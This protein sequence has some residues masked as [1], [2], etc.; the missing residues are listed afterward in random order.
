LFGA[1]TGGAA[2][3]AIEAVAGRDV[4]DEVI[5]LVDHSLLRRAGPDRY[6]AL[7]VVRE[8]AARCLDQRPDAEA[9]RDRHAAFFASEVGELAAE[10][11]DPEWDRADVDNLRAAADRSYSRDL[12]T[13]VRVSYRLL[14][15]LVDT[16]QLGEAGQRATALLQAPLTT[17][18]Q[19]RVHLIRQDITFRRGRDAESLAEVRTALE[20]ARASGDVWGVA[21][22]THALAWRAMLDGDLATARR[23]SHEG[24]RAA[25]DAGDGQLAARFA[26]VLGSVAVKSGDYAG[27]REHFADGARRSF[28]HGDKAAGIVALFNQAMVYLQEGDFAAAGGSSM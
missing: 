25:E 1:F 28:A 24:I 5:T 16:G 12:A 21:R 4:L 8:Y 26:N 2:L 6:A 13:A 23:L 10:Q 11:A 7:E 18:D 22:A 9:V 17:R 3:P 14:A 20:L 15:H 19:V 27:A